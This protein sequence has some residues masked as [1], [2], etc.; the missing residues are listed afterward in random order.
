MKQT[1]TADEAALIEEAATLFANIAAAFC[2]YQEKAM[3]MNE[4]LRRLMRNE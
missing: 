4:K 1:Y 2:F 3:T